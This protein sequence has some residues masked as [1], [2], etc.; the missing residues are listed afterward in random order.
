MTSTSYTQL[1]IAILLYPLLIFYGFWAFPRKSRNGAAKK[2]TI[3]IP[4]IVKPAQKQG[5]AKRENVEIADIDKRA[6]LKI[7]GSVG[8][9][10]FLFSI[11]NKKVEGLFSKNLPGPGKVSL[12]A[13]DGNKIDPAQNHPVDG[14]R[15]S[16]IDDGAMTYYGFTNKDGAWYIMKEDTDIGAFRYSR[17]ESNFPG[18]WSMRENLKY[19]YFN[20]VFGSK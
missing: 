7:I 14:Y 2:P 13:L 12:E 16:D 5:E 15:I 8:L 3:A 19:D 11:F 4:S 6:F 10:I 17:G 9:S 18:N 1:A 20:N